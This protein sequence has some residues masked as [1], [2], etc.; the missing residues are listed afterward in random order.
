MNPVR[1]LQ[2]YFFDIYFNIILSYMSGSSKIFSCAFPIKILHKFLFSSVYDACLAHLIFFLIWLEQQQEQMQ[3]QQQQK[4][5]TTARYNGFKFYSV[6][7]KAYGFVISSLHEISTAAR[8]CVKE[9]PY[10]ILIIRGE[11]F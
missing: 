8:L 11:F 10:K 7:W 5:Q 6:Y 4:Q 1:T 9:T 3:Q 2:T